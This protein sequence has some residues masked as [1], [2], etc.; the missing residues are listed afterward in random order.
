MCIIEKK[1]NWVYELFP[2]FLPIK[3]NFEAIPICFDT[4]Y[5]INFQIRWTRFLSGH[6]KIQRRLGHLP[7]NE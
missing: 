4:L 6:G 5:V 1:E 3:L 2:L 7:C